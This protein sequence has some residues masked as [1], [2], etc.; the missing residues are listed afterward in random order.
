MKRIIKTLLVILA[1]SV[2]LIGA[3]S[4]TETIGDDNNNVSDEESKIEYHY[5]YM[6]GCPVCTDQEK[7]HQTLFEDHPEL[8]VYK[9]NIYDE[10]SMQKL[11]DLA[12]EYNVTIERIA[13][14][15]TFVGGEFFQGFDSTIQRGIENVV[16]GKVDEGD[17]DERMVNLPF[18]GE[19][20]ISKFSL[21]LLATVLGTAD[22]FNVCSIG[23]LLLILGIVLKLDS[24]KKILF[25][26][27]LFILTTVS[28]Y[29]IIVFAW[30]GLINAI[31]G[32]LGLLE[33]F[34]GLVA[35]TA[36][37]YFFKEFLQF[38]KYGPTCETTGNKYVSKVRR[39]VT[40]VLKNPKS[41]LF[42]T[43]GIIILFA[44]VM[45]IVELPCSIGLPLVFTGVLA[46][47]GV[48]TMASGAYILMYLFFYMFI[49][50]VI[51]LG[52]VLT[53]KMWFDQENAVTWTTLAASLI[54][55]FLAY[56]YLQYFLPFL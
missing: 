56:Y 46:D 10:E 55:F 36:G 45:V 8:D 43:A 44:L 26:G 49:E 33:L 5:F 25:Y 4:G 38:Y 42:A 2:F 30:Y 15:M 20:D 48:T 37:I 23:A 6:D 31:I 28:V 54:M 1:I 7:F 50:L 13:V 32:Y 40:Q 41:G 52:A 21:P 9:H 24:R 34:I 53:K 12:E 19:T 47:A 3:V 35:L 18:I 27:G 17:R 11:D 14:P 22:G 16:K 39:K 29:G 51:F